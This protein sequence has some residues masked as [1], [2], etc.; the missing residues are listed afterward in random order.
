M[1]LSREA[2]LVSGVTLLAVPTIMYSL[3][4]DAA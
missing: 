1:K 4:S 2:K 3:P